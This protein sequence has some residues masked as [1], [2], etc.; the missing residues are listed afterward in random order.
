[1][2]G[3]S[4]LGLELNEE[5]CQISYYDREKHEPETLEAAVDN[6]QIPLILGYMNNR[7]LYGKEAKHLASV[8]ERCTISELYGRAVRQE[9]VNFAGQI[10]DAVWLLAKFLRLAL[11]KFEQIDYITFAKGAGEIPRRAEGEGVCTGF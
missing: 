3:G 5:F 1:M 4:I 9:R 6:Y 10:R 2:R 7:W 8:D 11:E